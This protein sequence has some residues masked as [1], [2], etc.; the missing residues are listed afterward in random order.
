[1]AD[2]NEEQ[3][4]AAAELELQGDAAAQAGQ[5]AERFYRHAQ[6]ILL[7]T[8]RL[9]SDAEEYDRRQSAF[10][11]IQ[12]KIWALASPPPQP[13]RP[14]ASSEAYRTFTDSTNIT[15]DQWHDGIGYDTD[16][17]TKV[18]GE[19]REFL[20]A[21]LIA[22]LTRREGD[23]R[24]VEALVALNVP[25]ARH[26][27]EKAL[28][29]AKP[30]LRLYIARALAAMGAGVEIDKI[31]ADILRRGT[32]G[33][34]LSLALD[35]A[36]EHATPYLREVLLDCAR[37]GK[38]DVRVHAAAL[39]L[40]LAGKADSPFDWAHRPFFL[41]FGEEDTAVREQ[42]YAE[43]CRRIGHDVGDARSK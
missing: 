27:F 36:A 23:W 40:Y 19:E 7:P 42:A 33:D 11:R 20:A 18:T 8:G 9:W 24:D 34:G 26:A 25:Q 35:L 28:P 31:I 17:L 10:D 37:N 15:Y 41:R 21:S 38:P 5:P 4:R 30:E 16:A 43:L 14:A 1:M 12:R 32:Y 29:R 39:S 3:R 13:I 2:E 22:R 6:R